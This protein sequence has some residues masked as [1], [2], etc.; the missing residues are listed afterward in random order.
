MR[1]G[2]SGV[3]FPKISTRTRTLFERMSVRIMKDAMGQLTLTRKILR[4][5]IL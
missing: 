2:F 5:K 4:K 3:R 1:T